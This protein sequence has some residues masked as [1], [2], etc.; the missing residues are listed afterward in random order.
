MLV[1]V[2][3]WLSIRWAVWSVLKAC[4]NKLY[5]LI[6]L[7][8]PLDNKTGPLL[9]PSAF[10]SN[11]NCRCDCV[12]LLKPLIIRTCSLL[13]TL[14]SVPTTLF[15]LSRNQTTLRLR[16]HYVASKRVHISRTVLHIYFVISFF[17]R[18]EGRAV[19]DRQTCCHFIY[20]FGWPLPLTWR[21]CG[22]LISHIYS[23]TCV[24][25]LLWIAC[26]VWV[27]ATV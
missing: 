12:S 9:R 17:S 8:R 21:W 19:L 7:K 14:M 26:N 24:G 4:G 1:F 11:N 15:S 20:A 22:R 3:A 16:P 18:F 10:A 13:R 5:T 27:R 23:R 6:P 25:P 2:K